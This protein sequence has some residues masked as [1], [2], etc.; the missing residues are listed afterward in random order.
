MKVVQS[1]DRIVAQGV[2]PKRKTNSH[3]SGSAGAPQYRDPHVA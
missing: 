2:P 1:R 3:V